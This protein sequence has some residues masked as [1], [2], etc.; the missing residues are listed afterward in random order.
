MNSREFRTKTTY[1]TITRQK[2][3]KKARKRQDFQKFRRQNLL[4]FLQSH[5]LKKAGRELTRFLRETARHTA[6][7]QVPDG[8]SLVRHRYEINC[9]NDTGLEYK[10]P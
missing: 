2:F 4:N 7:H 3:W 10:Y 5:R 6:L 8:S 1:R 9:S